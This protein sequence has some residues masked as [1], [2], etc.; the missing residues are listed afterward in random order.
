MLIYIS[1]KIGNYVQHYT[2][3]PQTL[4]PTFITHPTIQNTPKHPSYS[5]AVRLNMLIDD[6][7]NLQYH[8]D[9]MI[10]ALLA[11]NYPIH[12]IHQELLKATSIPQST[13]LSPPQLA[14]TNMEKRHRIII[15]YFHI[16]NH[17]KSY[18]NQYW[19]HHAHTMPPLR[20]PP[21]ICFS[22][23]KN[24]ADLI[25]HSDVNHRPPTFD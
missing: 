3:N 12:I 9:N 5:Q 22:R 15:P 16:T 2:K 1:T 24:V 18:I 13:L 17:L 7:T 11:K 8:L 6:D 23:H 10:R 19:N 4:H 21:M 20:S 14:D 25:L